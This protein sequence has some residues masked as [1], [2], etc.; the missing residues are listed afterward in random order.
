MKILKN[1]NIENENIENEN[2]ENENIENVIHSKINDEQ[3]RDIIYDKELIGN[4]F[5]NQKKKK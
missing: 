1:E 2:I 4:D 5:E 3:F